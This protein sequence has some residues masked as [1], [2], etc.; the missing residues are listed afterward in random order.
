M[1]SFLRGR[2]GVFAGAVAL[3]LAAAPVALKQ[4]YS[5]R[6]KAFFADD[7][8]VQFVRP[9]LVIKITSAQV[10]SDGTIT[11]TISI[12][13]PQGLPLDRN[14]VFTPGTVA[15]SMVAATIRVPW[16]RF[17]GAEMLNLIAYLNSASGQK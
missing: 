10:A 11:S 5:P 2:A 16:L 14:G 3:S 4:I 9:G 17:D 7:A 1:K 8:T 12:T 15:I 13:D 6:E